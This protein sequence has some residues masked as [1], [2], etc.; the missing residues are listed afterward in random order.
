MKNRSLDG[1]PNIRMAIVG[2]TLLCLTGLALPAAAARNEAR[3]ADLDHFMW[4]LAGQES[5]WNYFI[6]NPYSGAFGR[7]QI[8]PAN[9]NN[10]SRRYVGDGWRDQSP[11]NQELVARGKL[12]GLYHW[13]GDWS[14]VA[15]WWLTGSTATDRSTWSA[16]GTR[17]VS[18][19]MSLMTRAPKG[20]VTLPTDTAGS[21][22]M[23]VNSGDWRATFKP[24]KIRSVNDVGFRVIGFTAAGESLRVRTAEWHDGHDLLWLR[25]TS[26]NGKTGWVNAR[27]TLPAKAPSAA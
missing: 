4:G 15:Y 11:L 21:T 1:L 27:K 26:A 17:Y 20:A 14:R 6:R 10:W 3:G 13:L 16:S 19:V 7:Y 9:W 8:M 2:V 25:V 24:L 12:E 5:G 18:N 23:E 22:G